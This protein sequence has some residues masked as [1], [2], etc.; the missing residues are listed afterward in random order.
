M[1]CELCY[2]SATGSNVPNNK[3]LINEQVKGESE[4]NKLNEWMLNNCFCHLNDFTIII[5]AALLEVAMMCCCWC[6]CCCCWG[7]CVVRFAPGSSGPTSAH[8]LTILHCWCWWRGNCW[9]WRHHQFR[10]IISSMQDIL[11]IG[12]CGLLPLP[13]LPFVPNNADI[14]KILDEPK[15]ANNTTTSNRGSTGSKK[16]W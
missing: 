12:K 2:S 4:A 15:G 16:K 9:M 7:A 1:R 6:C 14:K 11:V 13:C 3:R 10:S 8:F 5:G